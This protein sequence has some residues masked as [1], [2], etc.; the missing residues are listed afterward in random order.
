MGKSPSVRRIANLVQEII[1]WSLLAVA[2]YSMYQEWVH[3]RSPISD[4]YYAHATCSALLAITLGLH[5]W[6][7]HSRL[8]KWLILIAAMWIPNLLV[9]ATLLKIPEVVLFVYT[10]LFWSPIAFLICMDATRIA[11]RHWKR[12][13]CVQRGTTRQ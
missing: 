4:I 7:K 1:V 10:Y 12:M 13:S 3:R 9:S 5:R 8:L 2:A 11:W 6:T